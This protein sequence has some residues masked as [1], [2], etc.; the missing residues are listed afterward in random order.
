MCKKIFLL[1][2]FFLFIVSVSLNATCRTRY[3]S[4]HYHHAYAQSGRYYH[5]L[6]SSRN[7]SAKGYA[8]WYGPRFNHKRT[9]SGERFNMYRMTAAHKTLPL[10]TYVQVTNLRNGRKVIVRVND[11]GPFVRNRLI[12][13]SY[14]AAKQ[15]R[16]VGRGIAPVYIQ[17]V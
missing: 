5:L 1:A 9:S 11:R 13:L 3:Y 10:S 12:D 6:H 17:A 14:A 2:G 7:Y 4:H 15:L 16:M 8:S